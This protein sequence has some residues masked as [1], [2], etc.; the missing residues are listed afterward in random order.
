MFGVGQRGAS[1]VQG[2]R[3][4]HEYAAAGGVARP[5][6]GSWRTE[7]VASDCSADRLI[8]FFIFFF[9]GSVC[10]RTDGRWDSQ[11]RRHNQT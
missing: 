1:G 8:T 4:E 5:A 11:W 7:G 2:G 3:R 9:G 6:V 10:M